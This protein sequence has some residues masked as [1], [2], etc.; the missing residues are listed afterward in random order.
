MSEGQNEA[1]DI[2]TP[3]RMVTLYFCKVFDVVW[4]YSLLRKLLN[5]DVH[6][7]LWLSVRNKY[8]QARSAVKWN[9]KTF[10]PFVIKQGVCAP[11]WDT[12]NASL[13]TLQQ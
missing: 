7:K 11:G 13:Q 12:L 2:H 1:K 10:M 8:S 3:L 6:G 5:V 4:Q 9:I